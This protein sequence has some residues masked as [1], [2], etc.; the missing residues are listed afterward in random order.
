MKIK[1]NGKNVY[2]IDKEGK[3]IEIVNGLKVANNPYTRFM[4]LMGK[5]EIKEKEGLIFFPCNQ[6]HMFFMRFAIDVIYCDKEFNVLRIT[7]NIKPWR[8]DKFIKGSYYVLELKANSI[9]EA[10][11][12][13]SF[14]QNEK[15]YI[16]LQIK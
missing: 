9:D 7:R 10:E 5:R 12:K 2:L 3:E 13:S 8:V 11:G 16:K 15:E 1:M 4:G 6:I 14:S